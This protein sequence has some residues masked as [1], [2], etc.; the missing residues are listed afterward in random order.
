MSK[1]RDYII[2]IALL[3]GVIYVFSV[4]PDMV[5]LPVG[6]T[7]DFISLL[8]GVLLSLFGLVSMKTRKPIERFGCVMLVGFG[9]VMLL[10]S[11]NTLGIVTADMLHGLTVAQAQLWTIVGSLV[12]GGVVYSVSS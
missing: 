12:M 4:N 7:A 1:M 8:P 11:G 10:S 5:G 3:V 9:L 2:I 6:D